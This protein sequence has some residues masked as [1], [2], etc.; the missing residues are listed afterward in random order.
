[1]EL[2]W[3]TILTSLPEMISADI[4]NNLWTSVLFGELIQPNEDLFASVQATLERWPQDFESRDLI[5]H[6]QRVTQMT[7]RLARVMNVPEDEM[8]NVFRG[9]LLH[10]I[11]KIGIPVEILY[12]PGPLTAEEWTVIRQH[13]I[14]ALE[15]ISSV[16]ALRPAINIPYCHHEKWNGT[17]YPRGL[18]GEEI[19]LAARIFA[20]VDVWDA[21]TSDRPYRNALPL[22]QAVE[23]INNESG[24]HFDPQVVAA[25]MY[26]L[27]MGQCLRPVISD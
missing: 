23:Y 5:E 19:P 2:N 8:I 3:D 16:P 6:T 12:K 20:V 10:D 25:F 24:Q 4:H 11:G 27:A 13:P 21:L 1:M 22:E 17:G 9:A 15:I 18:A 14:L 7:V 26:L